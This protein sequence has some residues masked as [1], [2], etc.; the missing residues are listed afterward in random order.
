MLISLLQYRLYRLQKKADEFGIKQ[1]IHLKNKI[2]T[3]DDA[4]HIIAHTPR[5]PGPTPPLSVCFS[6]TSHRHTKRKSAEEQSSTTLH[7]SILE[8]T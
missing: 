3:V 6:Y 4:I 8:E 1:S 7:C 2:D 5:Q